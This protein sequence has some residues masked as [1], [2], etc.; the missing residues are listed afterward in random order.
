VLELRK[1]VLDALQASASAAGAIHRAGNMADP[2][3]SSEQVPHEGA[4]VS[5]GGGATAWPGPVSA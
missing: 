5:C 4:R 1:T 3:L 2:D